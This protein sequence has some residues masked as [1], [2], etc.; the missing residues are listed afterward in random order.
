MGG[1]RGYVLYFVKP[2]RYM[3]YIKDVYVSRHKNNSEIMPI[4]PNLSHEDILRWQKHFKEDWKIEYTY[5]ETAEA[6]GNW[7]GFWNLLLQ[8]DMRQN[9]N[10][11]K[12]YAR[13]RNNKNNA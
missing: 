12:K 13:R 10:F 6:A 8:E 11:Y 3:F 7:L 9:P 1:G 5:K 2:I 4:I